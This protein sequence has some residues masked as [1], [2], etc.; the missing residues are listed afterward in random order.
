MY[1]SIHLNIS[2]DWNCFSSTSRF[3]S[4]CLL[5]RYW[6]DIRITRASHW[7]GNAKFIIAMFPILEELHWIPKRTLPKIGFTRFQHLARKGRL[8]PVYLICHRQFQFGHN[9]F[10]KM[11]NGI[12][13]QSFSVNLDQWSRIV[14]FKVV[15]HYFVME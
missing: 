5:L 12:P 10:P 14:E 2:F 13:V 1:I 9:Y 4:F 7:E 8:Y 11:E 6:Q 3:N 15:H